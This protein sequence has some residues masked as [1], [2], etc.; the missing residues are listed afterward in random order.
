MTTTPTW[1]SGCVGKHTMDAALCLRDLIRAGL[2]RG[3]CSANDI[4]DYEFTQPNVIGAVFKLLPKLGF[5]KTDR[6]ARSDG[7]KRHSGLILVWKLTDRRVAEDYWLALEDEIK[8]KLRV[9]A[10]KDQQGRLAI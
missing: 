2:M 10:E 5:A 8:D 3:E 9:L 4:G 6:I 7:E 1:A